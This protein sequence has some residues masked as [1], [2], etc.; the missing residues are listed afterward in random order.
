M[1]TTLSLTL[2]D[3]KVF[4]HF[5]SDIEYRDIPGKKRDRL[6]LQ[7]ELLQFYL[8]SIDIYAVFKPAFLS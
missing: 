2:S 4:L 3:T 6:E 8:G 5:N 7:H 1:S